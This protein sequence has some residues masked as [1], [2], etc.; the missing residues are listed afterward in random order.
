VMIMIAGI[1][2]LGT[3]AGSLSSFFR[4]GDSTD[5]APAAEADDDKAS[6]LATL[7]AEVSA[8]RRQV[9]ALTEQLT[10]GGDPAG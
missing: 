6:A 1:A 3:L 8:L 7:T 2:V 4:F 10:S 5:P 9:E